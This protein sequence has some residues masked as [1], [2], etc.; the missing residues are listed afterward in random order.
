MPWC[1]KCKIE[2]EIGIKKCSDC[3][4]LLVAKLDKKIDLVEEPPDEPKLLVTVT[5]SKEAVMIE[6]LLKSNKIPVLI[7]DKG[8]GSY[9]KIYLGYSILGSDIYVPSR[10]FEKASNLLV[11]IKPEEEVN[12]KVEPDKETKQMIY[13]EKKYNQKKRK[14]VKMLFIIYFGVGFGAFIIYKLINF[15]HK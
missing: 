8:A 13:E 4:S 2:Y 3:G 11:V 9:T 10:L 1:E 15:I 12:D 6:A 7:K 14:T 5:D